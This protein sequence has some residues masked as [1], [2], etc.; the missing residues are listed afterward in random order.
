MR[1]A[2]FGGSFNPPHL[3]HVLA[4]VYAHAIGGV[5]EVWVLPVAKH[6]YGKPIV[7]W[8]ARWRMCA[9]AFAGLSFVRLRDDELRNPHGYTFDLVTG[10]RAKYPEH[11][12]CL[13]GGTDTAKDLRHWHRGEELT[14]LVEVIAVPR[15]GYDDLPNALPA[16]SSSLVRERLEQG[17]SIADLV[18][19]AVADLIRQHGWYQNP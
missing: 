2:L 4:A 17:Q 14:A 15:R 10:L 5:D 18:P 16:L 13:V 19:T 6:A 9:A 8:D 1:I 3:G 12:W 11:H 7:A